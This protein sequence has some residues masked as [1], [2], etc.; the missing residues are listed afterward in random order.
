MWKDGGWKYETENTE[1]TLLYLA[2]HHPFNEIHHMAIEGLLVGGG[3]GWQG[4]IMT[5]EPQKQII[6]LLITQQEDWM[7]RD[8]V[9]GCETWVRKGEKRCRGEG[10][11]ESVFAACEQVRNKGWKKNKKMFS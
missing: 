6:H 5:K 8:P 1:Q 11:C 2:F 4:H 3:R 7:E 9:G 10:E